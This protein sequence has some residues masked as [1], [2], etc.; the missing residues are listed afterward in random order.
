MKTSGAIEAA[1]AAVLRSLAVE[2]DPVLVERWRADEPGAGHALCSRHFDEIYRFF[3]HKLPEE[4]DDL[5]QQTFLGLVR[6]RAQFRAQASFRTYLFTIAR[7]VLY[8]RLRKTPAH[9]HVDLEVS[10]LDELVSS[11]SGKLERKAEAARLHAA[12]R[13]LPVEQQVLLELYYWH[14]LRDDQ[15][16][17]M[18]ETSAVAIRGRLLRARRA[19]R[20]QVSEV[21]LSGADRLSRS[22]A[23]PDGDDPEA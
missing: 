1:E 10:S 17:E 3:E 5:T 21:E 8:T 11:P 18:F 15:L 9:V 20:K 12:L 22:M 4:A 14:E 6:S 7:N 2:E 16:A 13:R 19:L 23:E